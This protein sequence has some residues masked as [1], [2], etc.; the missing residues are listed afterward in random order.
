M[1]FAYTCRPKSP[2]RPFPTRRNVVFAI[3]PCYK[4][5]DLI[6][7]LMKTVLHTVLVAVFALASAGAVSGAMAA[8]PATG[9]SL[10]D[11][12]KLRLHSANVL[13][14]GADESPLY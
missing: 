1:L 2:V 7:S 11:P 9:G 3:I 4:N 13:V 10:P 6:L 14:V 12:N 8:G 5:D